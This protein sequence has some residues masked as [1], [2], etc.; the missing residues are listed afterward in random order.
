MST[1]ILHTGGV[2]STREQVF[3]ARTPEPEGKFYPLSHK[4]YVESVLTF[5]D[6]NRFKVIKEEHGLA[7]EDDR[8]FGLLHLQHEDHVNPTYGWCLGLRNSHDHSI[9]TRLAAGTKVFVCDNLA[10]S[11]EVNMARKHT[12]YAMRDLKH[13]LSRAIGQLGALYT[14]TEQRYSNYQQRE[15]DNADANDLIIRAVQTQA[16]NPMDIMSVVDGWHKPEH[17]EFEPRTLWSLFNAMTGIRKETRSATRMVA[18]G[19][20]LHG[21]FDSV[22]GIKPFKWEAPDKEPALGA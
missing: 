15:I 20:A 3:N 2:A 8:Y 22:V 13:L 18:R 1:L 16:I 11:G 12:K 6:E 10:F 7:K 14:H 4:D 21:L 17:K 19:E 9:S 5:L